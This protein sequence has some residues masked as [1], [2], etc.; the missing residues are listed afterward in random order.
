MKY[1]KIICETD[2]C[3]NKGMGVN[4]VELLDSDLDTFM[5]SFGQGGEEE[6]DYCSVCGKLGVARDVPPGQLCDSED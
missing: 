4:S 2:G 5:E 1:V 3:S 6:A